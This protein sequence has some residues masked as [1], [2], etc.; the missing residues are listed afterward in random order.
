MQMS[1]DAPIV[2]PIHKPHLAAVDPVFR[3]CI[4]RDIERCRA[5]LEYALPLSGR[6]SKPCWLASVTASFR[7]TRSDR[8]HLTMRAPWGQIP[9]G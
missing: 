8:R 6:T 9:C 3:A 4:E 1:N 5:L 7:D 2:D